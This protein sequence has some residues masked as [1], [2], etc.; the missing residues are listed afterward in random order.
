M[1]TNY[2]SL[3]LQILD[4]VKVPAGTKRGRPNPK[5][6]QKVVDDLQKVPNSLVRKMFSDY[7]KSYRDPYDWLELLVIMSAVLF[8]DAGTGRPKKWVRPPPAELQRDFEAAVAGR[9]RLNGKQICE[10]MKEANPDRYDEG[11]P[12]TTL[13]RWLSTEGISISGIKSRYK[14][15]STREMKKKLARQKRGTNSP[16]AKYR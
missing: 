5:H 2:R 1:P 12:A 10:A 8:G 9:E 15:P 7:G 14:V 4:G 6:F 16:K 3:L 11:L 13:L